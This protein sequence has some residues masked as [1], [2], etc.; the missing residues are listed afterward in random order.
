MEKVCAVFDYDEQYAR[1]LMNAMNARKGVNYRTI[2]FTEESAL[3]E[4]MAGR[5]LPLLVVGEEAMRQVTDT[6]KISR[7]VVLKEDSVAGGTYSD[8]KVS[9]VYK[10][11]QADSLIYSIVGDEVSRIYTYSD[12]KKVVGIYSP[13]HYAGKT[14][15]ALALASACARLQ[16]RVLYVNMEEFS[17]LSELLPDCGEG[18]MSDVLYTYRT[19]R[20]AFANA[21]EKIVG[22]TGDVYYIPPVRCADDIACQTA[23]EWQDF[24]TD[25]AS[26]G[27]YDTIILDIGTLV[28]EPWRVLEVCT[29]VIMPVREDYISMQKIKDFEVYMLSRGREHICGIIEKMLLPKDNGTVLDKGYLDAAGYGTLGRHAREV[30]KSWQ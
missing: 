27:M 20:T 11:Q 9:E 2:M 4:Y 21:L 5:Q 30:V 15:F 3:D 19:N 18:D 17:G 12:D 10:Y 24:I 6:Q 16:E 1:R 7:V 28:S 26:S 8:D 22:R 13:I 14:S 29:R 25:I 23:E